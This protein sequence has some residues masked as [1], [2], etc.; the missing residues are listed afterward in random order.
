MAHD[1]IKILSDRFSRHPHQHKKDTL[2]S[3]WRLYAAAIQIASTNVNNLVKRDISEETTN[4]KR[5]EILAVKSAL[6][7]T[8]VRRKFGRVWSTMLWIIL[9]TWRR[10]SANY[11]ALSRAHHIENVP[12]LNILFMQIIH[13]WTLG[14]NIS[15][16]IIYMLCEVNSFMKVK[17]TL[18]KFNFRLQVVI[19]WCII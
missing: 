19:K 13:P 8:Y 7:F 12:K 5:H 6:L 1:I 17:Q 14:S 11:L 3:R 9:K 15:N 2:K 16:F 18:L 10:T 4:I